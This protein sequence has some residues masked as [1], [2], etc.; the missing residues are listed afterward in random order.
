MLVE[1]MRRHHVNAVLTP[2]LSD[3]A[4]MIESGVR[5]GDLVIMMGCGNIHLL[6]D[7]LVKK[8]EEP[9]QGKELSGK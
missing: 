5:P 4:A 8:D 3:A 6:N 9:V 1:G 2:G 7:L